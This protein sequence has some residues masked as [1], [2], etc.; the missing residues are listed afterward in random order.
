MKF[1]AAIA[2]AMGMV[3]VFAAG[4]AFAQYYGYP[5]ESHASTAEEGMANGMANI[6]MSTGAANLMNAQAATQAEQARS[7]YLQ[8]RMLA[9]QT[10]F[11]MRLANENYRKEMQDKPL[12][13]EQYVRLS[14]MEAPDRLSASQLDSFNG[15]IYWPPQLMIPEYADQRATLEKLYNR[16]ALGDRS[17]YGPIKAATNAFLDI[18]KK[19][20]AKFAPQDF[21]RSKNFVQSLG[22][23]ANFAMR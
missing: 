6:I 20:I 13:M 1:F 4:P 10:Y 5:V 21:V 7:A 16:R 14:K 15:K 17:T 18:L 23:E 2:M 19:D 3:G 12:S 22:Y 8:N 11:D 9:T